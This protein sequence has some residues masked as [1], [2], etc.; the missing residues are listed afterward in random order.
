[1]DVKPPLLVIVLRNANREDLQAPAPPSRLP[2][3]ASA[4]SPL[5]EIWKM[6]CLGGVPNELEDNEKKGSCNQF[7]KE[8][9]L[10]PH[11][12]LRFYRRIGI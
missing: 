5:D 3:G 2:L 1:V 8:S 4:A 11:L 9:Y 10:L 12:S 6:G 7:I